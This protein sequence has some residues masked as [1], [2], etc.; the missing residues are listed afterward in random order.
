MGKDIKHD[1]D[2]DWRGNA[3]EATFDQF[4][5]EGFSKEVAAVL[6]TVV[7]SPWFHWS[8]TLRDIRGYVYTNS[9]E[10]GKAR[11]ELHITKAEE[12]EIVRLNGLGGPFLGPF[13]WQTTVS[14]PDTFMQVPI[15]IDVISHLRGRY[16]RRGR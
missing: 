10:T 15:S 12:R 8:T 9:K 3:V 7:Y 1:V 5:S 13:A 11:W 2:T 14:F 6:T 16:G 4:V